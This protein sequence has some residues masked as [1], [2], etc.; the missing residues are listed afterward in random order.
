MS[1]TPILLPVHEALFFVDS[2]PKKIATQNELF[3]LIHRQLKA[4]GVEQDK[5]S[6]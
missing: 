6:E 4:R 5:G 2:I 3:K 1:S